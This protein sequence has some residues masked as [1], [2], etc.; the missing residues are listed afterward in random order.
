M[1]DLEASPG[2]ITEERDRLRQRVAELEARDQEIQHSING[3]ALSDLA[4]TL[5]FVNRSFLRM[6]GYEDAREVLGRP[7]VSFWESE[8]AAE[9]IVQALGERG[10]WIGEMT[11]QRRDGE[12]FPVQLSAALVK[13]RP[14]VPSA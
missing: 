11:A 10:A 6:W 5:T 9:G 3:I 14:D 8:D 4:G 1:T 13:D 7:A 12:R 2:A